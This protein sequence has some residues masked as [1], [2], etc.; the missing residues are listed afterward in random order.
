MFLIGMA[1]VPHF[2]EVF[3]GGHYLLDWSETALLVPAM[4]L[5]VAAG[6]V[7]LSV[8]GVAGL[9][10]AVIAV[11]APRT[12]FGVALLLAMFLALGIGVL[13]GTLV[14]LARVHPVLVTLAVACLAQGLCRLITEDRVVLYDEAMGRM[15]R[16]SPVLVL[17]LVFVATIAGALLAHLTPLSRAADA[18]R[19]WLRR[20]VLVGAPYVLSSLAAG[21]VGTILVARLGCA[22]PTA[23]MGREIPVLAAVVMAGT[24]LGRGLGNVTGAVLAA[25]AIAVLSRVLCLLNA[26]LRAQLVVEAAALLVFALLGAVSFYVCDRLYRRRMPQVQLA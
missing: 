7:D 14:G 12:N 5:I 22:G 19:S 3:K 15:V 18:H 6:G 13:N 23:G 2:G 17:G 26:P 16:N 4:V 20:L 9:V 11:V 25:L 21:L 1:A 8:G 24:V 10:A